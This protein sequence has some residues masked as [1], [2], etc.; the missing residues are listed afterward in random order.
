MH[1]AITHNMQG[2]SLQ[3]RFLCLH[4]RVGRKGGAVLR[5]RHNV[6]FADGAQLGAFEPV[7]D[8]LCMKDVKTGKPHQFQPLG[9]GIQAD[10]A[11]TSA[12]CSHRHG[13]AA[14]LGWEQ[15]GGWAAARV[16]GAMVVVVVVGTIW[17]WETARLL[18]RR[19]D[20]ESRWRGR[21]KSTH[22]IIN[23]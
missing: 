21:G 12:S 9:H 2:P 6:G 18:G 16:D 5:A 15:R 8:A 1:R 11:V 14:D 7:L 10:A 4:L 20:H 22:H 17:M 19:V 13:E 3:H 23:L